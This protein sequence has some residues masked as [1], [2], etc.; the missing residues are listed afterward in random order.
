MVYLRCLTSLHIKLDHPSCHQLK[1]VVH[2]YCYALYMGK[3]IESVTNGC[4]HCASLRKIPQVVK[5]QTSSDPPDA[6]DTRFS[7][8]IIKRERQLIIVLREDVTSY[9]ATCLVDDERRGTLRNALIHLCVDLRPLGDPF[10]VIRTDPAPEFAALVQD[11]LLTRH[12]ISIEIGRAKNR[13]NPVADKDIQELEDEILRQDTIDRTVS[14]LSLTLATPRLNSRIRNRG[15]SAREMWTQRVQFS[16]TSSQ[17][18]LADLDLITKQ[19]A[20]RTANHKYSEKSKT[21]SGRQQPLN[22]LNVGDLIYLYADRNKS[23]ARDRYLVVSVE[24]SW[25]KIRK[26]VG[27]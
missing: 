14:A 22:S 11:E 26:F 10:A 3:S 19:H 2:R 5:E 23:S 8:D 27:S 4:H 17:I 7:A 16:N 18:P 21:P 1:S 15:L 24:N 20:L 13:D 9:T 25:C 6:I 12:R